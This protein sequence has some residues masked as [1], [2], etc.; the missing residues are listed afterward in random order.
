MSITNIEQCTTF[1]KHENKDHFLLKNQTIQ[2]LMDYPNE[3]I[4]W[5]NRY[6]PLSQVIVY[7]TY[8]NDFSPDQH[9]KYK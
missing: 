7:V 6:L 8:S 9:D 5:N 2:Y 3:R 4:E 1:Q